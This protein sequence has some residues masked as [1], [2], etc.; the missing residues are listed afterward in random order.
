L[1]LA[2]L[3]AAPVVSASQMVLNSINTGLYTSDGEFR[4]SNYLTGTN[5]FFAGESRGYLIFDLS[6]L[7]FG[8]Q[9]TAAT[10]RLFNEDSLNE[11]GPNDPLGMRVYG[12]PGISV[13]SFGNGYGDI[14]FKQSTFQYIGSTLTPKFA[15]DFVLS[16][17]VNT[18][19]EFGINSAGVAD[20]NANRGDDFYGYGLKIKKADVEFPKPLQFAFENLDNPN[21]PPP[22]P[23]PPVQ[24]VLEISAAAGLAGDYNG[25]NVVDAADYV[26]W[27]KGLGT[28]FIQDDYTIWRAHFGQTA[29]SGAGA[30]IGSAGAASLQAS[31]PEPAALVL[32]VLGVGW[33][34]TERRRR[35]FD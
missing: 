14:Q 6:G 21:F 12:L 1:V 34:W 25:N 17:D 11:V 33:L 28:T 31:V 13:Y 29:G 30:A 16:T 22:I 19:V 15:D 24:L 32:F 20:I 3:V 23:D 2:T 7:S 10:L 4:S 35:T 27:R 26:L 18:V 9:V 5:R 8:D